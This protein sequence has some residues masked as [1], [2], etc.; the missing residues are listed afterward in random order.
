MSRDSD[1]VIYMAID[2]FLA[3]TQKRSLAEA[4]ST[5]KFIFS[6]IAHFVK[7]C[8]YKGWSIIKRRKKLFLAQ[9]SETLKV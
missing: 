3:N 6:R 8:N 2:D 4:A 7:Y 5:P 1:F 9:F